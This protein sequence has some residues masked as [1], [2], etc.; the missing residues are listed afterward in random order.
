MTFTCV[1]GMDS[2]LFRKISNIDLP[3]QIKKLLFYICYLNKKGQ[4]KVC[5]YAEDLSH[6]NKYRNRT[7]DS[8]EVNSPESDSDK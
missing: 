1:S 6:I 4:E 3:E 2:I 5:Q 8:K 7:G